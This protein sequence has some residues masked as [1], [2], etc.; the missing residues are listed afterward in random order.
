MQYLLWLHLW[1]AREKVI[2]A[3]FLVTVTVT[4]EYWH[5]AILSVCMNVFYHCTCLDVAKKS[6]KP[7]HHIHHWAQKKPIAYSAGHSRWA[8]EARECARAT[9][10]RTRA[11]EPHH[12]RRRP[13]PRDFAWKRIIIIII[14]HHPKI[15]EFFSPSAHPPKFLCADFLA[16][17]IF[18]FLIFLDLSRNL[19]TLV[20]SV[21]IPKY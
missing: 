5:V 19:K 13:P 21:K 14:I 20:F 12:A 16:F 7:F 8:R 4:V 17:L 3:P 18:A 10:P 1:K 2:L 9:S 6:W 15:R 11:Q